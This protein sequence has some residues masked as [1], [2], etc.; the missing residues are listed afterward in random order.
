[1]SY[2]LPE[3]L[4][5]WTLEFVK[6]LIAGDVVES[7]VIEFKLGLP[8]TDTLTELCCSFA[9]S[10]GGY[11][12]FGIKQKSKFIV[13]GIPFDT[14]FVRNFGDRLRA[15]PPISYPAPKFIKMTNSRY[16]VIFHIPKSENGPHAHHDLLKMKF[17]KRTNKGKELMTLEELRSAFE[18]PLNKKINVLTDMLQSSYLDEKKRRTRHKVFYIKRI[19]SDYERLVRSYAEF[20]EDLV[21]FNRDEMDGEKQRQLVASINNTLSALNVFWPGVG[22]DFK[23]VEDM[24]DNPRLKDK[25]VYIIGISVGFI[26]NSLTTN[27][28]EFFSNHALSYDREGMKVWMDSI[29]QFI[30]LLKEEVKGEV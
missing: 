7:D 14:E 30:T 16:L 3:S 23:Q 1:M 8:E 12:V 17:W 15:T 29:R 10:S 18:E 24:I 19:E 21:E 25:F 27:G 6:D 26:K 9:N 28:I 5:Q 20:E 13:E 4:D 22:E 11:I 2:S